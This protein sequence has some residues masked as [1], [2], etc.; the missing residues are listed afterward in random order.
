MENQFKKR[1]EETSL[2]IDTLEKKIDDLL[3]LNLKLNMEKAEALKLQ[4]SEPFGDPNN[5]YN[6]LQ[7]SHRDTAREVTHEP[8][9]MEPFDTVS[10]IPYIVVSPDCELE[11]LTPELVLNK[12]T[13]EHGVVAIAAEVET[14]KSEEK[15]AE[16]EVATTKL[17]EP[18]PEPQID[19][20][21]NVYQEEESKSAKEMHSFFSETSI[22]VDF[23]LYDKISIIVENVDD[24]K[25]FAHAIL[26]QLVDEMVIMD[27]N[28]KVA[29]GILSELVDN[30]ADMKS[31]PSIVQVIL[32]ELILDIQ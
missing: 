9:K 15:S 29:D 17:K 31:T 10:S 7:R 25:M 1:E 19:T 12:E 5:D 8:V 13:S 27:S 14:R 16:P 4:T 6:E 11:K 18:L 20:D 23:K 32:D 2:K 28:K 30:I 26:M 21:N 22:F 24:I 3:A